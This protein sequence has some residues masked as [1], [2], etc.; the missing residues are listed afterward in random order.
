MDVFRQIFDW[1]GNTLNEVLSWVTLVLPDSPFKL[2]DMSLL[3]P[4]LPYVAYFIDFPFILDTL[5]AWVSCIGV[6]YGYQ[7]ILRFVRAIN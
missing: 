7:V 5:V 4:Y 6:Y 2:L 3:H 1:L